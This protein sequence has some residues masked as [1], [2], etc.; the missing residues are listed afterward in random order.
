MFVIAPGWGWT[1]RLTQAK[2]VDFEVLA[3]AQNGLFVTIGKLDNDN[4]K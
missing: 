2:S 1:S 4:D 3:Y